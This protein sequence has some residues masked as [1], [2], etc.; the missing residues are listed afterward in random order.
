MAKVVRGQGE[1]TQLRAN[2]EGTGAQ[3]DA[4]AHPGGVEQTGTAET[5]DGTE[6]PW[7]EPVVSPLSTVSS[8]VG[9]MTRLLAVCRGLFSGLHLR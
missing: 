1:W 5:G 6:K 7:E 2:G 9:R 8:A 3:R 4:L